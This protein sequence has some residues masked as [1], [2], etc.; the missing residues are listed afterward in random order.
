MAS[1]KQQVEKKLAERPALAPRRAPPPR[2]SCLRCDGEVFFLHKDG[3]AVC[4][5]CGAALQVPQ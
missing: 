2:E 1:L 3:S 5:G 4:A